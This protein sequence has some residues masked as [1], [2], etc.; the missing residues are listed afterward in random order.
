MTTYGT[1]C[2]MYR[3]GELKDCASIRRET[4]FSAY[5]GMLSI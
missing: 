1:F 3:P 5:S 2:P 4:A